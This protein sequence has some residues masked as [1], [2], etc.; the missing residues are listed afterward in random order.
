MFILKYE[1]KNW[2]VENSGAIYYELTASFTSLIGHMS[3]SALSI[4]LRPERRT[5]LLC[6]QKYREY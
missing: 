5:M 3:T 2:K 6:L 1:Y 4:I